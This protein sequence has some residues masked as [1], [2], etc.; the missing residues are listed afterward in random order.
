MDENCWNDFHWSGKGN[1]IQN[2]TSDTESYGMLLDLP[3]SSQANKMTKCKDL[4]LIRLAKF[5]NLGPFSKIFLR[6][7]SNQ[8]KTINL[9]NLA[10]VGPF[11]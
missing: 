1:L 7:I 9:W 2:F 5:Q 8:I 4:N 10:F 11:G 6:S 3:C